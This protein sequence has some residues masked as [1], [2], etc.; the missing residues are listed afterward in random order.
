MK[1]NNKNMLRQD[2]PLT[3]FKKIKV[4]LAV[5][6]FLVS[7]GLGGN[8]G[9]G[10]ATTVS[11]PLQIHHESV[12]GSVVQVPL[13]LIFDQFQE[14]LGIVYKAPK[15]EL[16]KHV[17]VNLHGESVPQALAKILAQ[18]D[19]A[20]TRDP[21]GRVQ[22]IFVVR[23]IPLRGPEEQ[24][25]KA[26]DDRSVGPHSSSW[27]KRGRKVMGDSQRAEMDERQADSLTFGTSPPVLQSGSSQLDEW[28][29]RDAMDTAGMEMIPHTGYPEMEVTQISEEDKQEI[30]QSF[31][32]ST[33]GSVEGPGYQEV[34]MAP[35]SE[36][37]AQDILRSLNQ[38]MGSFMEVSP[39]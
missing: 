36:E 25:I 23:K 14:Q 24:A 19:Y 29:H 11:E 18:W 26:E 17:S 38:S 27:G 30:L 7:P 39:P 33:I 12:T 22:E 9:F 15:E 8:G 20:L 6:V 5:G 31:N 3:T 37:E 35:V 32:P 1:M 34:N 16:D 21:A 2:V 4:L 10:L 28:E 13:R